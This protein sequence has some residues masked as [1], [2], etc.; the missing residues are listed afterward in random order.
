L[1]VDRTAFAEQFLRCEGLFEF[2]WPDLALRPIED[3]YRWL[4][5][6]YKSI[7]P[8]GVADRL[9]WHRLGAKTQALI[10][11]YVTDVEVDP[12]GLEEIA[13]DAGV[14]EALRDLKLFPDAIDPRRPPTVPE[15]LDTLEARLRR[16]LA[17]PDVH[18]VWRT[19]ADRLEALRQ[20]KLADAAASVRFL[21]EILDLARAVLE[22][23]KRD[24]EGTLDEMRVFPDRHKGAFTQIFEEYAPDQTPEIIEHVVE[25]IDEIVRPV[26]D[27]GWQTSAPGDREVRRQ[28]RLALSRNAL[29]PTGDLYDRAYAYIREN[30]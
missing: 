14:F 10:A 20:A 1:Y 7:A 27:S 9:L 8:T 18:P 4:A 26:R 21:Q 25:Q 17:G 15:V 28:L 24:V 3:D 2:L 11:E 30:Y 13:V 12:T 19:L 6:V 5:K 22:A 23:E 29:P 16:K